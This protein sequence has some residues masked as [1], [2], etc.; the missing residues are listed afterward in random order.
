M[1]RRQLKA[2][3]VDVA[4]EHVL[5]AALVLDRKGWRRVRDLLSNA[6]PYTVLHPGPGRQPDSGD[7]GIVR[8][9]SRIVEFAVYGTI[10][11]ICLDVVVGQQLEV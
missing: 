4:V 1:P 3:E 10:G 2:I 6:V 11:G 7:D 8:G 9:K 5:Q